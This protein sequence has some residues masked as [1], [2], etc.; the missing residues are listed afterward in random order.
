MISGGVIPTTD[1]EE[2]P[3][4]DESAPGEIEELVDTTH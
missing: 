2:D 1:E 4:E 3:N